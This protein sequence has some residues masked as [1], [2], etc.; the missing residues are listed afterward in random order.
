MIRRGSRGR[1][2]RSRR[3]MFTFEWVL[4]T[5]VLSLGLIG[6]V[7]A[8]RSAIVAHYQGLLQCI[9]KVD[10][11]ECIQCDTCDCTP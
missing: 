5:V 6:G 10:V 3:G 7:Y 9:C 8:L 4:V 2:G 11:C 1:K